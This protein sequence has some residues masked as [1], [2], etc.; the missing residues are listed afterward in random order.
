MAYQTKRMEEIRQ[1][2]SAYLKT[3]KYKVV[4]RQLGISKNTVR[5]Y[6]RLIEHLDV[7][8]EKLLHMEDELLQGL[9]YPKSEVEDS[10]RMQVFDSNLS[11]WQSELPKV[12]VTRYLL[13]QEYKRKHPGGYSYSQFCDRLG[14]HME[15]KNITMY[16]KH[17]PGREMMVDFAGKSLHWINKES[18]E[19]VATQVLVVVL[20]FSQYTFVIALDSQQTPDVVHGLNETLLFLGGVP[21]AMLSDNLAAVVKKADRYEPSF[22]DLCAQLGAHYQMDLQACRVAKPKDKASVENMVSIVYTRI[23]AEL[24]NEQFFSLKELNSAI[25][26]KLE[27]HNKELFQKRAG[28]RQSLFEQ[29]EKP[30]LGSLPTDLFVMKKQKK[31]KV[32]KNYHIYLGSEKQY[33]SV[34]YS[35]VG[36]SVEVRYTATTLEIFDGQKRIALH[37]RSGK[38]YTTIAAHMPEK[39]KIYERLHGYTSAEFTCL[40]KNI[41]QMTEWAI[42]RILVSTFHEEQSYKS[43]LGVLNLA[44]RY[45]AERL[46]A[47]CARCHQAG[48]VNYGMLSRI[49]T[50]N[51]DQ[52]EPDL[53]VTNSPVEH[54]NIRGNKAYK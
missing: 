45:S 52:S 43:C 38:M 36:K 5:K 47:A 18:G 11:Y 35:H 22:T 39:H 53:F 37:E 49:L 40:A 50:L 30:R 19:L 2:L 25:R 44:K 42:Q 3:G 21:H 24:R 28:S 9:I 15:R 20:P 48:Q 10:V 34:H 33:Y 6:I 46:E 54:E 14:R 16:L 27:H 8:K 26:D 23:Y 1:I 41:G 31:L 12:G 51:L 7:S 4:A 17:E 32:G 13:W 29:F